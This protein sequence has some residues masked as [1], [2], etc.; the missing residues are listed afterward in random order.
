[1]LVS[2]CLMWLLAANM[3]Q[4]TV[5]CFR[6]PIMAQAILPVD[7]R[8]H[9]ALVCGAKSCPPIRV[10]TPQRLEYGLMAAA[11]VFCNGEHLTPYD[12]IGRC[13]L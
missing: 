1:M 12:F 4:A 8:I 11:K 13:Y 5:M 3:Q 6:L 9:F 7:P 2:M 10:Y